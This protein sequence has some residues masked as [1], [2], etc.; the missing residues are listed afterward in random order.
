[1]TA[2]GKSGTALAVAGATTEIAVSGEV[3]TTLGIL[4]AVVG[5]VIAILAF[6]DRRMKGQLTSHEKAEFE[7]S[8][9]R[10]R[11]DA[12]RNQRLHDELRHLRELIN[13]RDEVRA[14][15]AA[16]KRRETPV[17]DEGS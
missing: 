9:A 4:A 16:M 11:L 15:F 13:V 2:L 7:R 17:P 14:G 8:D 3:V 1:M 6:F 5:T 12:E 10:D